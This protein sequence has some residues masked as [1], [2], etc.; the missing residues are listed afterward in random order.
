MRLP[1]KETQ[2]LRQTTVETV[3]SVG[4]LLTLLLCVLLVVTVFHGLVS[5]AGTV[6]IEN[7]QFGF[8]VEVPTNW[9]VEKTEDKDSFVLEAQNRS[10]SGSFTTLAVSL[11]IPQPL[12]S[13][14]LW[15]ENEIGKDLSFISTRNRRETAHS[16]QWGDNNSG[17]IF[18]EYQGRYFEHKV[19]A[20]VEYRVDE[21]RGYALLAV[22]MKGDEKMKLQLKE[23]LTSFK[24]NQECVAKKEAKRAEMERQDKSHSTL[25]P[26][27]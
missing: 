10:Q 24:L 12:E 17:L 5:A 25:T 20:T 9:E 26:E 22:W 8:T 7:Q 11:Q 21:T 19:Q 13:F 4:I 27:K 16:E 18:H 2:N 6:S 3:V 14:V 1:T 15:A 23:M